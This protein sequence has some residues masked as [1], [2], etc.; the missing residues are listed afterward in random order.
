VTAVNREPRTL[1]PNDEPRTT[2]PERRTP[3]DEPRTV[4]IGDDVGTFRRLLD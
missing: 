3:N 1:N 4:C 2:N